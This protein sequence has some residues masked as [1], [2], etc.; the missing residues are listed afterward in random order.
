M[1]LGFWNR[2]THVRIL[3]TLELVTP[4]NRHTVALVD[5]SLDIMVHVIVDAM[6]FQYA[7]EFNYFDFIF[8]SVLFLLYYDCRYVEIYIYYI[9]L[10][11]LLFVMANVNVIVLIIDCIT[12]YIIIIINV[13]TCESDIIAS[14]INTVDA[15]T[16]ID[17]INGDSDYVAGLFVYPDTI[18][19]L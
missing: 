12:D 1:I 10:F 9:V 2:C 16:A 7:L 14:D 3:S 6:S 17:G 13:I 19:Q 5:C 18:Q 8:V 4:N 15:C 11:K